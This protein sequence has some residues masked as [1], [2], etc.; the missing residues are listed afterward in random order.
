MSEL[1][2]LQSLVDSLLELGDQPAVLALRKEGIECWSYA[3]L[4]DPVQQLTCGLAET[5]VGGGDHVALLA[6]N[7]PEWIAACLAV[8]K[9][10]AVVVPLD[11][12]FGD[13]ELGTVLEDSDARFI[14]TT[15]EGAERLEHLGIKAAPRPILLDVGE[16]DERSWRC[17][18]TDRS[19]EL[20]QVEPDD[21]AAL[22]YTSGTTGT[23]KGVPLTHGNL[24]FQP[25]T[26]LEED[27]LTEDDRVLLPLPLHHA[28]PFVIGMLTPLAAGL[29][30]VIPQSLAGPQL[31]RALREGEVS[32]IVGVPQLYDALY[33]SIEQH[34]KSDSRI[35]AALFDAG[36]SLSTWLRR[37]TRLRI[38]KL[39][40]RPLHKQFGPKLRVL[41]SGGAALDPDL[42]WKLEGLG[43]QIAIGYGLT[44][45]S[46]LLTLNPPSGSKLDS[47]GRPVSGVEVCIDPSAIPDEESGQRSKER[48]VDE[49]YKEG[50]ILARGPNV[51]AG[52]RNLPEET[53]EVFTEDGWYRT[54]DLGYF[55]GDGYLYVTGRAS[56][57]IVTESGKN[58]QPENV[59][60]VYLESPVIS[61]TGVL[62]KDSQLVAVIVPDLGEIRRRDGEVEEAIRKAVEEQSKRL[63]SHQ[64][65]SDYAITRESLEYTQM[66]DLRRHTLEELYDRAKEGEEDS[67]EVAGPISPEEMSE[68]DRALLENLTARQVWDVLAER[69]PDER[70]TPDTSPQLDLGVDSMEWINLSMEIGENTGVE[71]DEEAFDRIDTVRDL[72]SEVTE[73]AE[74]GEEAAS[75]VSPLEQPEEVLDD[76]QKR[77]LEP[78]GP[79]MSALAWI[80]FILNW[81]VM[82]GLFRL[83]VEG[84]EHLPKEGPFVVTPNHASYLDSFALAAALGYR[85]LRQTYW[86]GAGAAFSNPLNRFV[87]RLAQAVPVEQAGASNLAF[88]AGVLEREKNLIWFPEGQRS[89]TG[90]LQQFEPGV[91]MLLNHFRVPV[92]PVSI[93]GTHEA[94]PPGKALLWPKKIVV[95]F[96]QP[97]DVDDLEQQ[98]EGEEPQDRIVRALRDRVAKLLNERS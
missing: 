10:G 50:E 95:I 22:F 49:P 30:I 29:P 77:W 62:Q 8:I 74:A 78:Q 93:R 42:A 46:P 7:R 11:V 13:E 32:L 12:K 92:V 54:E 6:P 1:S 26:L 16:D 2:T 35:V 97:L 5:G 14:F 52:Y 58:I 53:E 33:S 39:L 79:V 96:G 15:T 23:A 63:R 89:S 17:L 69:Y 65:I 56:T 31:V 19:V 40:M 47:P 61:E 98:G 21:P 48:R 91:G 75:G 41:A 51:F 38:G 18:L 81:V 60:E 76:E 86:A 88:G 90:E 73:Q 55:D 25:N 70:L 24:V 87:S 94:M 59:E 71:L 83:R 82:R 20:P 43:W 45:T 57:L 44:E 80:L 9:A 84:L 4:A 67:D 85:R 3:E 27:L 68:E 64:R 37:R 34:S 72:L 36:V 66:G 28:Y